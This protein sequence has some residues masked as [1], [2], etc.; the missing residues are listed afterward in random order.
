MRLTAPRVLPLT[1]L[2]MAALL[3]AKCASLVLSAS[4]ATNAVPA[5]VPAAKPPPGQAAATATAAAPASSSITERSREAAQPPPPTVDAVLTDLRKR[6]QDLDARES[7]LHARESVVAAAA[8]KLDQR[9]AELKALQSRLEQLGAQQHARDDADWLAL[10]SLYEKMKPRDAARIFNDLDMK[11][12]VKLL[13]R[14]N[15]R[16]AAAVLAA[17]AP[18]K[19]RDTTDELARLREQ[20]MAEAN[21]AK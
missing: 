8:Q 1:M 12:L 21:A 10:V 19:A 7:A 17:M 3:T 5:A 11:V 6:S 9:I 15:G 14:M 4:A 18:D 16:R 13:D 2:A 20:R